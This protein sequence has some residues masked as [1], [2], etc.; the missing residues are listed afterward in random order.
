M[1]PLAIISA[2]VVVLII[3]LA[4][5]IAHRST[6]ERTNSSKVPSGFPGSIAPKKTATGPMDYTHLPAGVL[7][8]GPPPGARLQYTH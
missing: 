8:P 5:G 7:P 6:S 4:I 2:V 1:K 3:L